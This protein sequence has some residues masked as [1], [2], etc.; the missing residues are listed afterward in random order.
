MDIR[1]AAEEIA[2]EFYLPGEEGELKSKVHNQLV[3]RIMGVI[4]EVEDLHL[5]CCPYRMIAKN[6]PYCSGERK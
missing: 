1:A 6:C 4:E 2:K 5:K 3:S